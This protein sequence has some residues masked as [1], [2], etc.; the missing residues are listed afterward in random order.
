MRSQGS[1]R[2]CGIV[3]REPHFLYLFRT[4]GW[5]VAKGGVERKRHKMLRGTGANLFS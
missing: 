4:G 1:V 3:S 5:A 2:P